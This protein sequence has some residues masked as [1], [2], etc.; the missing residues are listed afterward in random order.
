[1][2]TF[3][4][5]TM[6]PTEQEES[7]YDA[8]TIVVFN[9]TKLR[10][11]NTIESMYYWLHGQLSGGL[12]GE[13]CP[14]PAIRV[15]DYDP[16]RRHVKVFAVRDQFVEDPLRTQTSMERLLKAM[17]DEGMEAIWLPCRVN[18]RAQ[19][20]RYYITSKEGLSVDKLYA[21]EWRANRL[22]ILNRTAAIVGVAPSRNVWPTSSY[23]E[24]IKGGVSGNVQWSS[25]KAVDEIVRSGITEVVVDGVQHR[26]S[27]RRIA[28][29]IQP[30]SCACIAMPVQSFDPDRVKEP[31]L[32]DIWAL[33]LARVKEVYP[34]AA[35]S[36]VRTEHDTWFLVLDVTSIRAAQALCEYPIRYDNY[37]PRDYFRP[38]FELNKSPREFMSCGKVYRLSRAI[39]YDKRRKGLGRDVL[40][41]PSGSTTPYIP[42]DPRPPKTNPPELVVYTGIPKIE[43]ELREVEFEIQSRYLRAS[44]SNLAAARLGSKRKS[45]EE[46]LE[47]ARK[48]AKIETT[49]SGNPGTTAIG[50]SAPLIS[51]NQSPLLS[52]DEIGCAAMSTRG[53]DADPGS[54]P[55]RSDDPP[56]PGRGDISSITRP[57]PP[58]PFRLPPLKAPG[59]HAVPLANANAK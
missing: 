17:L 38:V 56:D 59:S 37:R 24:T 47:E 33:P 57:R 13:G 52:T 50:C 16:R 8:A 51:A 28:Y 48:A 54:E 32:A 26:V 41:P 43:K 53:S 9:A 11:R 58:A 29:H 44:E 23:D 49:A 30:T 7:M 46:E 15:V 5:T 20:C 2:S 22:D 25:P 36:N 34:E 4:T 55:Q 19:S 18:D 12:L 45:L 3:D 40:P 21:D 1:M 27:F 42:R 6:S 39:E 14:I 10:G 35:V 31:A